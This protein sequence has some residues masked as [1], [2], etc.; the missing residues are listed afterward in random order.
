MKAINYLKLSLDILMVLVFALLFNTRVFSGMQFH[1]IAGLA[2]GGVFLIHLA[3]NARW[4]KR[5]TVNLL[6][7]S[8]KSRI[9]YLVQALLFISMGFIIVSGVMISKTIL[10]GV[11]KTSQTHLF[12]SLH[13]V[14]SYVALLLTGIHLGLNWSWVMN[15]FKLLF[16]KTQKSS[17]LGK[18]GI[19]A[20]VLAL[21][22]GSYTIYSQTNVT[23]V[24]L[25]QSTVNE[26]QVPVEQSGFQGLPPSGE[27]D[28]AGHGGG[29]SLGGQKGGGGANIFSVLITH[30]G[31]ISIF[32]VMTV[33]GVKF[34][35]R[36]NRGINF[37]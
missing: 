6:K 29:R 2:L 20:V 33:Y 21:S 5:V 16:K 4:V 27:R 8:V 9:G 31:I 30:L 14:V 18:L 3:L 35:S 24:S 37:A 28:G 25:V 22:V 36:K 32:S 11:F 1:E 17:L 10:V 23:N 19:A 7:I 12:Q 34:Q 13:I 26:N 15:K